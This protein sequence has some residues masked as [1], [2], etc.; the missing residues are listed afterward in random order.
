MSDEQ[1]VE[2]YHPEAYAGAGDA[3]ANSD[4]GPAGNGGEIDGTVEPTSD[5]SADDWGFEGKK[6]K[7]TREV[8]VGFAAIGVLV[9]VF[10]VVVAKSF[11][12]DDKAEEEIAGGAPAAESGPES[13]T[14]P[15][16][17]GVPGEFLP[18]GPAGPVITETGDPDA[19]EGTFGGEPP[20]EDVPDA[21]W[22]DSDIPGRAVVSVDPDDGRFG[23]STPI[24]EHGNPTIE[25]PSGL[26]D[27]RPASSEFP[28]TSALP[29]PLD[30]T[31]E[32]PG[33][34]DPVYETAGALPEPGNSGGDPFAARP[35]TDPLT[36][37][38]MPDPGGPGIAV[39]TIDPGYEATPG[40]ETNILPSPDVSVPDLSR[41]VGTD[42]LVGAEVGAIPGPAFDNTEPAYGQ[43]DPGLVGATSGYGAS[44]LPDPSGYA[45]P[46]A[47]PIGALPDPGG[48]P[49]ALPVVE[50]YGPS[51]SLTESASGD[52]FQSPVVSGSNLY[53]EN[54]DPPIAVNTY[55]STDI[56]NPLIG[57][58]ADSGTASLSSGVAA[59]QYTV[60]QGDSFWTI[61]KKVYG[62]GRYWQKLAKYNSQQVPNPDRMRTGAVISIPDPAVF[63][64]SRA[65]VS[66]VGSTLPVES[67]ASIESANRIDSAASSAGTERSSSGGIFFNAQGYP[68]YRIGG[69]D[70]LTTIAAKHLGRASRWKQIYHM[71]RAE[72]QT[73]D[74][75]QI[76]MVLQLPAD[77]SRV[78]LIARNTTFR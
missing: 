75:L 4:V 71:N 69:Q 11:F 22:P 43:P 17:D 40:F 77:A 10:G 39:T 49:G 67:I 42:R 36:G 64:A 21:R 30:P 12:G 73:P 50:S 46:P 55:V 66:P 29:S 76:G 70:T 3:A 23:P 7:L 25:R 2:N 78:P 54:R 5:D 6:R 16:P 47:A 37:L 32:L 51:P 13:A 57:V 35:P 9:A 56:G 59:Q 18:P 48:Y 52:G 44:G 74:K 8:L 38:P 58:Q 72:L 27:S 28:G 34:L 1:Y 24:P 15:T 33:S 61:S 41:P 53:P 68:M 45:V 65:T 14:S 26:L 31:T 62:S 60:Q 20:A 63:G 19:S